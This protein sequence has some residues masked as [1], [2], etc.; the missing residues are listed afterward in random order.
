MIINS[1]LDTDL[2]KL[3]MQKAEFL[4]Y[5]DLK[6]RYSFISRDPTIK[7]TRK[8]GDDLEREIQ[9][10]DRLRLKDNEAEFLLKSSPFLGQPYID[11]FKGYQFDARE[12]KVTVKDEI[13]TVH[14]DG[15]LWRIGNWEVPL[16]AIISELYFEDKPADNQTYHRMVEKVHIIREE[17]LNVSDFGTR[18]RYSYAMQDAF[19]DEA[20]DVL[21]G[22]SNP[23]FAMKY[24]LKNVGTHAHAWFQIA[25]AIYGYRSAN[26]KALDNWSKVYRG[27][28]GIALSD[29]F[30]TD[31]FLQSFDMYFAKLF[32][33]VRHDS[34]DPFV[35]GD[36]IIKHYES[37]GIDPM[38]KTIVFSDGLNIK[39]AVAIN[40]YFK[41]RIKVSFG[42]GTN[43]TNDT[44]VKALN[45]VLKLMGVMDIYGNMIDTVKLSDVF[46]KNTARTEEAISMAKYMLRV[47]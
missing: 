11:L 42:I 23:H 14:I 5:N 46:G 47:K 17:G 29:T 18:R 2:Y 30:T 37:M 41:G 32:D 7:F 19:I 26:F 25:A 3:T 6:G 9:A 43:F 20:K 8:F 33:G 34:G 45:V 27:S 15:H 10:M 38:T 13:L 4:T 24:G 22:T 21:T 28:L 16:M 35:F 44:G 12:V 31:V 40:S 39:K 1:V 36:K